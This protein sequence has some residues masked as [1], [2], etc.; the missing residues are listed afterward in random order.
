MA[1]QGPSAPISSMTGYGRA[2][3]RARGERITVEITAVNNRFLKLQVGL[4]EALQGL[5]KPF[6]ERI[7]ARVVRGAV[8]VTL[9]H[10]SSE[11]APRLAL[12][13]TL[14]RRYVED[15]TEL[16]R[17]LGLEPP[18][19]LGLLAGLPGLLQAPP[20]PPELTADRVGPFLAALDTALDRLA[21]DREREGRILARDL[22]RR[23]RI[24][25]REVRAVRKLAPAA[26]EAFSLRLLDRIREL[27]GAAGAKA[28]PA[29][30]LRE[31]AAYAERVDVTEELTRLEAH[32]EHFASIL[33]AGGECGKR[34][35][36]LL[37]EIHREIN[38]IGAKAGSA[39]VSPHVLTIKSEAE[40]IREQL[41]NLE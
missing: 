39:A 11:A 30:V 22:A 35:E 32:L 4:P 34:L 23:R 8:A 6:E 31:V 41:Q 26:V 9:S 16:A 37:Q 33:E 13:R 15:L 17:E 21:A 28:E 3:L 24:L 40:K 14:A 36:F 10:E 5:R 2:S 7:R 19:D 1:A 27:L 38:T 18:R 25:A 29:D 12:D 20:P